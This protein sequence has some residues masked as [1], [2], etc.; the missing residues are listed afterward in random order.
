[1]ENVIF[2]TGLVFNRGIFLSFFW[3]NSQHAANWNDR[4]VYSLWLLSNGTHSAHFLS[5]RFTERLWFKWYYIIFNHTITL[6]FIDKLNI[7]FSVTFLLHVNWGN[8]EFLSLRNKTNV[9]KI[10]M[11]LKKA[12]S[13]RLFLWIARALSRSKQMGELNWCKIINRIAQDLGLESP[14]F[15][16]LSYTW[17]T[18]RHAHIDIPSHTSFAKHNNNGFIFKHCLTSMQCI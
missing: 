7:I 9:G 2:R 13:Y 5:F 12:N 18:F 6:H 1:M 11:N 16:S 3:T 4:D 10:G 8:G 17:S 15:F 14:H